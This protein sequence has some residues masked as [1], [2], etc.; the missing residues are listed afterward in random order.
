MAE[1]QLIQREQAKPPFFV[2]VDLGGTNVKIGVVDDHGQT[3]AYRRI[4]S[5]TEKGPDD[6]CRR[7]AQTVTDLIGEA[8]LTRDD[9]ARVGLGTPGTMDISS[10]IMLEPRN[11]PGW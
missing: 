4:A 3:L 1:R 2:G 9:V 11:L 10:G 8:G 7:M 5:E 6:G